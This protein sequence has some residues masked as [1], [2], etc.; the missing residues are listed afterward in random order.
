MQEL[1]QEKDP[2]TCNS[3]NKKAWKAPIIQ[4]WTK[5]KGF[6]WTLEVQKAAEKVIV[7]ET[8]WK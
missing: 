8:Y 7:R 1:Q 2:P 5:E 4:P 3:N 6:L